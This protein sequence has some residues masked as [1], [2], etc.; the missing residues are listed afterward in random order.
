[1]RIFRRGITMLAG[2]LFI[3][4]GLWYAVTP[5]WAGGPTSVMIVDPNTGQAVA[6]HT[7]NP[8]YQ[9]LVDA[10]GAY[11]SPTGPTAP[12]TSVPAD[13]FG[14]E[15]RLTWLVHDVSVWRID[16]VYLTANDGIWLQ[17]VSSE[18]GSGDLLGGPAHWQRPSDPDALLTLLHESGV[19]AQPTDPGNGAVETDQAAAPGRGTPAAPL[20]LV[21]VGSGIAG[22]VIGLTGGRLARRRSSPADRVTLTG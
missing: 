4:T 3:M 14:C 22:V 21:A 11:V 20:G 6:V 17:S 1:M 15:L 9:Q 19:L 12:P 10:V 8:R 2:L 5:A 16:R 13:C 7:K 18:N